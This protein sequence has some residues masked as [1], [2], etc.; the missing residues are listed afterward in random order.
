[1][2]TIRSDQFK[3]ELKFI[4]SFIAQDKR[5]A[6]KK[7]NRELQP[8]LESLINN[9]YK[10]RVAKNESREIVYKGYTIPYLIDGDEIIILGI[11]NQ[12]EWQ[13]KESS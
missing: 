13:Q 4:L 10:G 3:D 9:P 12:N 6:A 1:M 2:K 8:I 5:S 11:F 7:F